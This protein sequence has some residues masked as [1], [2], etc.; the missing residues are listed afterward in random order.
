M[1]IK[2]MLTLTNK[3]T[4]Q[5]CCFI[6]L[7]F[8]L[9]SLIAQ[10]QTRNFVRT[11]TATAPETNANTLI[12]KGLREVKQSTT[13]ADGL[14]RPEQMVVKKGSLSSAGN[15]DLVST[16]TYDGFGR[17]TVSY[18]PFVSPSSDGSHKYNN[19]G[20]QFDFYTGT[21][22]PVAGQGEAYFFGWTDYDN[23]PLN[24]VTKTTAAGFNWLG[25]GR[26]VQQQYQVNATSDAVRI[27]NVTDVTGDF[28]TYSTPS[29]N[30]TYPAGELYKNVTTD[31]HLKQVVEYKNKQGQIILKKVQIDNN[32]STDHTGWLCTYYIYDDLDN[33]RAV[34]QPKAVEALDPASPLS[35][36]LNWSL[37]TNILSEL[38]FRYEYDAKGRM[39]IK[40][41]P[42]AEP[43]YMVY[44]ARDRLVM[45]QDGN[46]RQQGKWMVTVFENSLDR[47]V[48]TGLLT[49]SSS[50]GTHVDNA[51]NS[52]IYPSTTSG[53][54]LLT[55]TG[56]DD[57]SQIPSA[58][59]L[60]ANLYP[61]HNDYFISTY[62]V[63]PHYAQPIQKSILTKGSVTWSVTKVL[64]TSQYL[65]TVYFYDEKGRQLQVKHRNITGGVDIITTQYNFNG[66][67]IQIAVTHNTASQGYVVRTHFD[68]DDLGRFVYSDKNINEQGWTP[69]VSLEYDALGRVKNKK[70]APAYNGW[71][72]LETLSYDY[73]IR[74]WLLGVNR[75]ELTANNGSTK[76]FAFEL[77]YDKQNNT[78]GR[79]FTSAQHNGNITG[80]V[81]ESAGDGVR[82]KY[83]YSYDN[84]NRLM[85]GLFEQD[86]GGGSWAK[87]Q[88]NFDVKIGDGT[89]VPSAYDANGNI[90]GMQQWG[91][92]GLAST[93][94]DNLS[95]NYQQNNT[96][97]SLTNKL[98]RVTDGNNDAATKLGD[99]KDGTNGGDDYSYDANGNLI[100]DNN[101]AAS[102]VTY[103]HLDLPSTI[104]ITGKGTIEYVYDAAGV[105]LKKIT[106]ENNASVNYNGTNYTNITITTTTTYIGGFVYESK[107][108]S[109]GTLNTALG[110][111]DILQFFPMQQGRIRPIRN[112]N[113]QISGFAYDY[114]ITDHLGNVRMILTDENKPATVYQATMETA[115][116]PQE[117]SEFGDK[118]TTTEESKPQ[119]FDSDGN[120]QK[121]SKT[122]AFSAE[123]RIG[124]GVLLKVMAGDKFKALTTAWYQPGS[125]VTTDPTLTAIINT[126]LN[127]MVPSVVAA[128]KGG[129]GGN[130]SIG[131]LQPGM[132][133][134]LA[135]QNTGTGIPKAYL[136]WVIL[137]E[138]QFKLVQGNYGSVQVPLITGSMQKQVLQANN[139][140]EIEVKKNGFLY[141]YVSNESKCNVYFD[142]IRIEHT[143]GPILEETHY[144]PF[145][146]TMAGISS[147]A[148]G[149][150]ENKELFNGKELNSDLSLNWS[151]YG[152]RNNYDIQTGRF[153]SVDPL[154]SGYTNY[155]PYQFAGN[156]VP[157]AI[158]VDGLE[159]YRVIEDW[160]GS[161]F[162]NFN[163]GLNVIEMQLPAVAVSDAVNESVT[164]LASTL[165][166]KQQLNV[167]WQGFKSG[168]IGGADY[169]N[170]NVNPVYGA[171]NGVQAQF[172]QKDFLSGYHM[173]RGEAT[174][175]IFFSLIPE[176]KGA[177]GVLKS[178]SKIANGTES[179]YRAM[180]HEEFAALQSNGGLSSM[181]GKELFVS[182]KAGYSRSYIGRPGY[183]VLVKFKTN[184]GTLNNLSR[185]GVRD[186]SNVVFRAG[187]GH[188]PEVEKGW[189]KNGF[190]YFKGETGTLNVGLGS[191]TSIFNSNILS[192]NVIY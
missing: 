158:D 183:D 174:S 81:W 123:N 144:Y 115:R 96:G 21:S 149:L 45:A 32:P 4:T 153:Q 143:R 104:T 34:L 49:N 124:P 161:F 89:T 179:F 78:S 18:L 17:E 168:L 37:N 106:T 111:V 98:Y 74:G 2:P 177:G 131:N 173:N 76:K 64:G 170:H 9:S 28:G 91:L 43:L 93:Q 182:T 30:G 48:Q 128:G 148:F 190:N 6:A 150:F 127:N 1:Q 3:K 102:S 95:Y 20:E 29:T 191:N 184:P 94:I 113:N 41:V 27:W 82:R 162:D 188:L 176:L 51:Y 156:E 42:G 58:S 63:A 141:V 12:T 122:N 52:I 13:Y 116:R 79:N 26:G 46:L 175:E 163:D 22:S 120:N 125:D 80:M 55:Q 172:T 129:N 140:A 121:V 165:T 19:V 73:N 8:A 25:G 67:P 92:K 59:G 31:E 69:V 99:F 33:L 10:G 187:F 5:L 159:P 60:D 137:D 136:N 65:Y 110:Y 114:F 38:T 100:S 24:R 7:C 185:I 130:A 112:T 166:F 84:T 70:L 147:K 11:W 142:D 135:S 14:G 47:P 35:Q 36:G 117:L 109:N 44:D 101:K 16:V 39:I 167:F 86:N 132:G 23:S 118:I 53:F 145:G 154:A 61:W 192:Y 180:S 57:Y 169:I 155:A 107:S 186:Q 56:Y 126:L 90:K 72:G 71:T 157:N 88:L 97:N 171:F 151:E 108:Y 138:E 68:Y 62:N 105:K 139:G 181:T 87:D 189:M 134:F 66:Q 119:D 160:K 77:G 85:Q 146:L 50:L 164:Q 103:N 15:T 133:D 178:G 40:K 54:E 152:F 83:D 75:S